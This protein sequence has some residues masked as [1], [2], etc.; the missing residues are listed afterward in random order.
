[1][2]VVSVHKFV[3]VML[4]LD[5]TKLDEYNLG[6]VEHNDPS[7][8]GLIV[9]EINWIKQAGRVIG[10]GKSLRNLQITIISGESDGTW[11][12]ELLQHLP[13]N[14]SIQSLTVLLKPLDEHEQDPRYSYMLKL[15]IF[16]VLTPFVEQQQSHQH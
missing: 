8:A 9:R 13:R 1:M 7:V 5:L 16:H 15:D 6:M 14:R 4:S 10:D 2:T 3:A 11:L 12:G